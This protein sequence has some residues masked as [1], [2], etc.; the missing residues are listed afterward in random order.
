[1]PI[2]IRAFPLQRPVDD[3]LD[4]ASSLADRRAV[5]TDKFYRRYGV[6]HES[7]HLQNT[8]QG[9]WVIVVTRADELKV[10]PSR[11]AET[12]DEFDAWFKAQVNFLSGVDLTAAPL[13]P[14][15]TQVFAWSDGGRH[16]SNLC[17]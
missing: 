16:D 4:F 3:L 9:P 11:F 2:V 6:S 5:E 7:W 13:G 1:M 15:T 10:A 17:A 12:S 8:P 14:P